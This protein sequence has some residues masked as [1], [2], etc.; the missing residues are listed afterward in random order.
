MRSL[1]EKWMANPVLRP[2][3]KSRPLVDSFE[4]RAPPSGEDMS[5]FAEGIS[6]VLLA[7]K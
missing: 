6:K 4:K 3:R 2:E 5:R 1:G 7:D